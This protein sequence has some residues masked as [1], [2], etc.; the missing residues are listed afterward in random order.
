M[1]LMITQI[2]DD[3]D[4]Q[5]IARLILEGLSDWFGILEATEEYIADRR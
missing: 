3:H 4:K 5:K 2:Q 1:I